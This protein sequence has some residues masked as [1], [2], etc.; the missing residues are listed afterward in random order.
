MS[1]FVIFFNG[2]ETSIKFCVF[3]LTLKANA[4][5]TAEK[6]EKKFLKMCLRI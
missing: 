5:E 3:L 2:F 1:L 6:R 4:D